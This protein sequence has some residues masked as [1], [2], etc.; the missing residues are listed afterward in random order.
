MKQLWSVLLILPFVLANCFADII[1]DNTSSSTS[2][3]GNWQTSIAANYYNTGSVWSRDGAT[4]TWNFT[5]NSTGQCEVFMWWTTTPSR[6]SKIPVDIKHAA[7]T[8]RIYINQLQNDG[9]WNS[10]GKYTFNSGISYYV[11]LTAQ[12][13]PTSTCADAVKIAGT[14]DSGSGNVGGAENI[15]IALAY[16]PENVTGKYTSTLKNNGF[17]QQGSVWVAN[18]FGKTY[19]AHFANSFSALRSALTT[20]GAIIV[21]E[22]HSNYGLGFVFAN[23]TEIKNQRIYGVRYIDDPR[24]F[25]MTPKWVAIDVKDFINYQAYPN[26]WPKFQDGTSGI[27]PYTFSQGRPPYNYYITYKLGSNY[28]KVETAHRSAMQR[29]P[30]CGKPAWYSSAG[31]E[32]SVSN[33]AHTK[34][35]ITNSAYWNN[36]YPKPHYKAKTIIYTKANILNPDELKYSK[37]MINSCG[38][39]YQ[40]GEPFRHGVVFYSMGSVYGDNGV[41]FLRNYVQGKSDYQI[42]QALQSVEPIYDYYDFSKPP[43]TMQTSAMIAESE[44]A[45]AVSAPFARISISNENKEKIKWL[46]KMSVKQVFT[47]LED[48][49]IITDDDLT[50]DAIAE[51]L[52]EKEEQAVAEAIDR[53]KRFDFRKIPPKSDR[54]ARSF[55][56][57]RKV[58]DFFADVSADKLAALYKDKDPFARAKIIR[59]SGELCDIQSVRNMLTA[60]LN[61]KAVCEQS[62]PEIIGWPLRVCDLAYNQLVLNLNV[63]GVLRTI[64]TG[65]D[66]EDRDYHINLL[67]EKLKNPQK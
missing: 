67:K 47:E 4:F 49:N 20:P 33:P 46:K 28:Y 30:D 15:F 22:G 12:P 52:G 59:A 10:L 35:F 17:T 62:S 5:P 8:A 18:R 58:L 26:W 54:Y 14:S 56:V 7:G 31:A 40:Y 64:G 21:I 45:E 51:S 39:G 27:L 6:S 66:I 41:V 63:E 65:L 37:I 32:P 61:D 44:L 23:D 3:V 50:I 36:T 57:A 60:A 29:F 48:A 53:I 2:R 1:I 34:Y 19:T 9:Q 42:W 24:I 11:K 38:S 13:N 25:Q 43:P 55:Y 16:N